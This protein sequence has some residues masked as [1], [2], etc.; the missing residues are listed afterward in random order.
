[1]RVGD[2]LLEGE[3][4][5]LGIEAAAVA[6]DAAVGRDHAVAGDDDRD[7]VRA[8]GEADGAKGPG[9]A[10]GAGDV[11]VAAGRAVGDLG[12]RVPDGALER[13]APQVE[14][15]GEVAADA[16][17]VL[18]ELGARMSIDPSK[19]IWVVVGDLEQ[20]EAKVRSLDYGAVEVWDAYGSK[21]R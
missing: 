18:G 17:E 10:G 14:G 7:G 5:A 13:G 8:V 16:A 3:Q 15:D 21:L 4:A 19:L 2:A 12:E 20:I 11:G 1:M 6:T 9:A